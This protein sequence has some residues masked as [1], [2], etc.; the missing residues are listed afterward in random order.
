MHDILPQSGG[1]LDQDA[2]LWDEMQLWL[3]YFR[4]GI[5]ISARQRSNSL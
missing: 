5:E 2:T 1:V 3:A 4:E